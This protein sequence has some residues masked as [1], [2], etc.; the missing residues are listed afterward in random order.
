MKIPTLILP[1]LVLTA[2]FGGFFLRTAFT[3]PTTS[4]AFTGNGGKTLTCIV[5]GVKCKG[6]AGFFTNLYNGT[7]GIV[8]IE[9]YATEHRVIFKYNPAIITPD[10][11]RRIMETPIRLRDGSSRQVFVCRSMD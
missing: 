4:V 9:T 8:N 3:Q 2:L 1:I 6:T 7:A 5:D 10:S 11:I